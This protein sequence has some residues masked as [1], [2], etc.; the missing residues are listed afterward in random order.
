MS[1]SRAI[2]LCDVSRVVL[3]Q[4]AT[5]LW[6][7]SLFERIHLISETAVGAVKTG[8]KV[9]GI[10]YGMQLQPGHPFLFNHMIGVLARVLKL[11][12]EC[13]T[14]DSHTVHVPIGMYSQQLLQGR[15]T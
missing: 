6:I 10:L 9:N 15:G 14:V 7:K 11:L 13:P 12:A 8:F 1:V 3:R 5:L 2:K 4:T